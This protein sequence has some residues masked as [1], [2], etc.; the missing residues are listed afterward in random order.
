[1]AEGAK[2]L[3][4]LGLDE[5][6][7]RRLGGELLGG[8][9]LEVLV[10]P[11]VV[12]ADPVQARAPPPSAPLGKLQPADL[13]GVSRAENALE[14]VP[15][16]EPVL[17]PEELLLVR[18][19]PGVERERRLVDGPP[20]QEQQDVR[21]DGVERLEREAV[22]HFEVVVPGGVVEVEVLPVPAPAPNLAADP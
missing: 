13:Q 10:R 6:G 16:E 2:D 20:L 4:L 17:S 1:M 11:V 21:R 12:E 5:S 15:Y 22:V 19:C 3:F 18:P 7:L 14:D 9:Q 8:G